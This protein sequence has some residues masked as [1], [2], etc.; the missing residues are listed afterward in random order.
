MPERLPSFVCQECGYR[1]PKWFGRC[2]QCN[3][4]N[5]IVEFKPPGRDVEPSFGLE[6]PLSLAEI[7]V[8]EDVKITLDSPEI[9]R[10]LGGGIVK[11]ACMLLGGDPGIGKSTLALQISNTLAQKGLKV[12]YISAEES[13]LQTKLRADRL[14]INSANLY[15][16]SEACC[17]LIKSHLERIKPSLLV[18]DSIQMIYKS[19]ISSCPGSVV[20][21]RESAV[22][23]IRSCKRMECA[24]LIIGHVTKEGAIAGPRMLEHLV[25]GVFY[26][27]G[28]KLQNFRI[29]RAVKNRYGSTNEIGIF[30]M[31]SAGLIEVPN[32]SEFFVRL[33]R[34]NLIGSVVVPV[35]V[36]S[37]T[38]IVELQAL[39]SKTGIGLPARKTTGVEHARVSMIVAVLE[40]R[41]GLHLGMQD[42]F[43][44]AVGGVE[45]SE[46]AC[47]L[48][49]A[50]AITSSFKAKPLQAGWIVLGEIG[51]GGEIRPVSYITN[52]LS[53]AERLGFKTALIPRDNLKNLLE[54]LQIKST[55]ISHLREAIE[56]CNL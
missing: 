49:I 18:V 17:E 40:R 20:Q 27:E 51:L 37:R 6:A 52:R 47:D 8:R 45:I 24:L 16:L 13:I 23:L 5:S 14:S 7:K 56:L 31:S 44:N 21:V 12:L 15:I 9:D 10:V 1:T 11:G 22:E 38:L 4:Y 41:C 26:F 50:L 55:P 29:L 36:G 3:E 34:K 2:P 53:E 54:P 48:G 43:V 46:P 35:I 33:D 19:D 28:E 32:P 30:E 39:T 25:D 42:I